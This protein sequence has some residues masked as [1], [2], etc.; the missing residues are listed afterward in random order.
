[1]KKI[2]YILLVLFTSSLYGQSFMNISFA[3]LTN[4]TEET[5]TEEEFELGNFKDRDLKSALDFYISYKLDYSIIK[6]KDQSSTLLTLNFADNGTLKSVST[7]G[8][9]PTLNTAVE[10]IFSEQTGN[11]ISLIQETGFRGQL[12]IPVTIQH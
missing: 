10:K 6:G 3:G 7:I 11:K 9:N 4:G 1:M 12:H 8:A 2:I 5:I